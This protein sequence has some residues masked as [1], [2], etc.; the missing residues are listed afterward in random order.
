[1]EVQPVTLHP[2]WKHCLYALG[3]LPAR[4]TDDE[5]IGVPDEA[6]LPV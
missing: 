5:I 1:V 6:G 3:I 2:L 4:E